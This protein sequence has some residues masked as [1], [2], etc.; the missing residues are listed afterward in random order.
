MTDA[1]R[2]QRRWINDAVRQHM[3]GCSHRPAPVSDI[4]RDS[5][6]SPLTR[7]A[8][9]ADAIDAKWREYR[10]RDQRGDNAW[11]RPFP[12]AAP[13]NSLPPPGPDDPDADN[14]GDDDEDDIDI[15]SPPDYTDPLTMQRAEDARERARL[16]QYDRQQWRDMNGTLK[17]LDPRRADTVE[18]IRRRTVLR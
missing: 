2:Q 10:M 13:L 11:R 8:D 3:I 18:V 15:N 12:D 7:D 5:S 16:S 6:F 4:L 17:P 1:Q 9:L 14:D